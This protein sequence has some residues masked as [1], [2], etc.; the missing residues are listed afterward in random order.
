MLKDLLQLELIMVLLV[1][2]GVWLRRRGTITDQGRD[3]LTDVLMTVI[4]PC[5]IFLSFKTDADMETLQSFL[6]TIAISVFVMLLV[7][8]LGKALYRHKEEH[9]E[10][11]LRYG[12]INSNAL[13]IGLPVIQS[14]LGDAGVLQQSMYMIF[15]RMFCWS[16]GLSLYTG[17]KSDWKSSARRLMTNGCMI[18]ATLGLVMMLTGFRLPSFLDRT[19]GYASNCMM[20][21]SMLLIGVVLSEMDFK[22]LLRADVWGFTAVRLL[23]VPAVVLLACRLF[24]VPY[25]VAATCTLLSGMPAASL[26]A[27]LAARYHGDSE[28]G[29]LLVT[30]STILSAV[31]IPLWFMILQQP[32]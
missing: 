26:T 25:I 5:N 4:L 20:L 10:K 17:V 24:R 27:V 3:C 18:A 14:L 9:Q 31:T 13:F 32:G 11:V 12:L 19:L 2:A 30:V 23:L 16:Y 22:Q 29:A 28:L 1:L 6:V 15:V 7:T 8:V 21:I